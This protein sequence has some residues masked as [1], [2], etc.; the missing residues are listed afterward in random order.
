MIYIADV[1]LHHSDLHFQGQTFSC[2]AFPIKIVQWQWMSPADLPRLARPLPSSCWGLNLI[3]WPS[4]NK[5]ESNHRCKQFSS[6]FYVTGHTHITLKLYDLDLFYSVS[7]GQLEEQLHLFYCMILIFFTT[8]LL[9][10]NFSQLVEHRQRLHRPH[11]SRWAS[12]FKNNAIDCF[13]FILFVYLVCLSCFLILFVN[14]ACLSKKLSALF[15]L[16]LYLVCLSCLFT[17]FVISLIISFVYIVCLY[18]LFILF[19]YLVCLSFCLSYLF[20]L[21]LYCVCLSCLLL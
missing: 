3:W 20:I 7:V 11:S 10:R 5:N 4:C 18:F 19:V 15:I 17:L 9:V 12:E 1:V 6:T 21:F 8:F 2:Y 14:L 16:F 13:L